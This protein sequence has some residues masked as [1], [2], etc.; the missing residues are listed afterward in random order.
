MLAEDDQ[1]I[2]ETSD[3]DE[4]S[5]DEQTESK[6]KD[7]GGKNKQVGAKTDLKSTTGGQSQLAERRKQPKASDTAHTNS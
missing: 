6:Q 3:S 1:N 2:E 7:Q 5:E 4:E